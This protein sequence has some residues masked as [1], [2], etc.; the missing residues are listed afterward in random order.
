MRYRM[1]FVCDHHLQAAAPFLVFVRSASGDC[2]ASNFSAP[3]CRR[4]PLLSWW[5]FV[6]FGTLVFDE[7]L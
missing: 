4:F 3:N 1:V 7:A 5:N 2:P 6:R